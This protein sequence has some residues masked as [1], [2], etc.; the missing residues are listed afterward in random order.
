MPRPV[1]YE[2][3]IR[4]R[5]SARLLWP[6]QDD[7]TI[8][9]AD[10]HVTRLVGEVVDA[11]HLHGILTH[12]TSVN[13][14]VISVAA[15]HQHTA[16]TVTGSQ[17]HRRDQENTMKAMVQDTYGSTD[18]LKFEDIDMPQIKADEVLVRVRAAGVNPGDW[19]I[20][21]GL[22]YIARPVYGMRQ[23]KNRVR[24]TDFAGQ[25]EAVGAGVTRFRPGDEV[26]G[27][28]AG[29]YAEYAAAAEA[30]LAAKPVNL[31]FEQAASV[32][33]AGVVALQALRDHGAVEAGQTA[34][35]NGASGGIG[36]FAVQLAK[37]YGVHVTGVC[38]TPN[39]DLVGSIGADE[40]IDYTQEDFTRGGRRYDFILDNVSDHSLSALRRLLTPAG[41]LVPNGGRFDNR[42]FASGG[43][44]VHAHLLKRFADRRLRP[45]LVSLKFED[46]LLL[47]EL[48]E[49][50]KITPVIDRT[51]QLIEAPQ[52]IAHVGAGHTRG[53]VVI[54]V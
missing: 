31:T 11:S 17:V 51:Y 21:C 54:T 35:V 33:M 3:V 4:G 19:A 32:P 42:W 47:K 41:A 2:I 20:M 5:A 15:L 23:P 45:F 34:L 49:D 8:D 12:L 48:I 29:A 16:A 18:V 10:H 40:V 1:P 46:L 22:P 27:S 53:K 50:G 7:F 38:S 28:C 52:A 39:V 37:A 24:G 6:L 14:E 9:T 25:V 43:R 44:V 36:T 13:L 30:T 26:F